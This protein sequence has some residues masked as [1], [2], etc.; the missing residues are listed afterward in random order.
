MFSKEYINTGL[1]SEEEGMLYRQ[2]FS[3]RQSGDYDDLFDWKAIDIVPLIPKVESLL[4][5]LNSFLD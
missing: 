4:Q 3:M 5:K 2:L 1:L